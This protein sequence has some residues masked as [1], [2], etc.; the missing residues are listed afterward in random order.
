MSRNQQM[1]YTMRYQIRSGRVNFADYVQRRQRI[2]DGELLG[3]QLFPPDHDASIIPIIQEAAAHTT[4]EE[5]NSYLGQIQTI[6]SGAALSPATVPDAPTG[7]SASGGDMEG[8][9]SFTPGSDGGSSIT[10]YEY[11]PVDASGAS[12]VAFSPPQTTSTLTITSLPNGTTLRFKIRAVNAIGPGAE[13]TL[14]SITPGTG[15]Q[16][17]YSL[18]AVPGNTSTTISFTPGTDGGS[19]IMNY[20]YSTD[21]GATFTPFITPTG[22]VSSVTI[23]GLTNGVTY[24][25]RLKATDGVNTSSQSSSVDITVGTPFAPVLTS[26]ATFI[27]TDAITLAFTQTSNGTSAVTNYKYSINGGSF[28]ALSPADATTPITISGLSSNTSYTITLKAVNVN[29]D[30][31]ESNTISATTFA[32]VNYATFTTPGTSSW[33]APTGVTF[34]QYLIVGGG[35]GGGAAYSKITVLGNVL[36]TDT[37]QVGTYWINSVN[38]TNGRYSG[39]MYFGTNSGQNSSSFTNP[40]RLTASQDFTPSGV[41]YPYNKWYNQEIVYNLP[42]ALVTTTNY[43]S[44]FIINST[45]CNNDSGGGGGGAGGQVRSLSGTNKYTVVPGTT[46]TVIV[47][48]GGAGGV[49]GTDT[50]AS[51][52]AGESSTFDTITA[53]GG[54]GGSYSRLGSYTTNGFGNGGVGGQTSGNLVGGGGGGQTSANNYGRYNSGGPGANGTAVNFDGTGFVFYGPG[55]TGGVPNTVASGTTTIN[56]GKGGSGTGATLNSFASGIDGGYGIVIIKYYT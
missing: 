2:Q 35:G 13:S 53:T 3:L 4:V 34:V 10:N 39:R 36:V 51:G 11:Y 40:I 27:T 9:I 37:P 43:F 25:I 23:T 8:Y 55:G 38:L 49:G 6:T 1:D 22:A 5:L 47:G 20:L 44:P 26:P 42:G 56:I 45:Y 29:G 33:T 14:V 24:T 50:E 28:T 30:S 32:N 21:D 7:L 41:T 31:P 19:P 15:I 18:S 54:S 12:W 17:P 46:Y 48:N 52:S 16:P